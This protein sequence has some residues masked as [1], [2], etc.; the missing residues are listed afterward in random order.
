MS[1]FSTQSSQ[2]SGVLF[3]PRS[4]SERK[5]DQF[6]A[7]NQYRCDALDAA[8][9]ILAN[10]SVLLNSEYETDEGEVWTDDDSTH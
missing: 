3:S 8:R 1:R 7:L 4:T 9:D 2:T 10:M 6:F 5:K